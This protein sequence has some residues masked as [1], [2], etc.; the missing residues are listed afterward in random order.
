MAMNGDDDEEVD[1][2]T[3]GG[4]TLAP[5]AVS[6]RLEYPRAEGFDGDVARATHD[7]RWSDL[8]KVLRG[9]ERVSAAAV[10]AACTS[11]GTAVA[12]AARISPP[13]ARISSRSMADKSKISRDF[14]DCCSHALKWL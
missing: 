12:P 3:L 4:E 13:A 5:A 6:V 10:D 11:A 8:A 9:A 7:E 14:P 1:G 2:V